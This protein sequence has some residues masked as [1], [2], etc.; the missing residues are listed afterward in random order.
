MPDRHP[1]GLRAVRLPLAEL[2]EVLY[3]V[4]KAG[5]KLDTPWDESDAGED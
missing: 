4:S 3:K 1:D 5:M 2:D